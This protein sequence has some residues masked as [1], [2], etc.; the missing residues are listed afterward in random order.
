[1]ALEHLEAFVTLHHDGLR[2]TSIAT[3]VGVGV[4]LVDRRLDLGDVRILAD[5]LVRNAHGVADRLDDAHAVTS[6]FGRQPF[7]LVTEQA[8]HHD[9]RLLV[10]DR[11]RADGVE[12]VEK[13]RVLDQDQG[14]LVA[15][16]EARGDADA[17]VLLAD[18]HEPQILV[19]RDREQKTLAGHDIGHSEHELDAALLDRG[20]N[21]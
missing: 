7:R 21:F 14:A 3:G 8:D 17:L 13:A 19:G 6:G 15:V 1:M 20:K 9:D 18:A 10:L 2:P 4:G 5:Q 16:G 12:R 11:D